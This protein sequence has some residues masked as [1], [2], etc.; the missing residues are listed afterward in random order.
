ML[1]TIDK[2]MAIIMTNATRRTP[3]TLSVMQDTTQNAGHRGHRTQD[4][5]HTSRIDVV[6]VTYTRMEDNIKQA[7]ITLRAQEN[8]ATARIHSSRLRWTG[9][10]WTDWTDWNYWAK[11]SSVLSIYQ[12]LARK[13]GRQVDRQTGRQ[14]DKMSETGTSTSMYTN[15]RK[16]KT[17]ASDRRHFFV[18]VVENEYES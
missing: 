12:T 14:V 1:A 15:T 13:T 2:T 4:M 7:S 16:T 9:L 5:R 17:Q 6:S 8:A 18:A 11:L 10:D 3:N